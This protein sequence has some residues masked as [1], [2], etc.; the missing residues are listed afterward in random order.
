MFPL[1]HNGA[2][3]GFFRSR[4][5]DGSAN[6]EG[7][8]ATAKE[9]AGAMIYLH[10]VDILHGDLTGSNVLLS[11]SNGDARGFSAKVR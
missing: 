6:M 3:R 7:I 1:S 2:C 11:C 4:R 8:L 10:S 9:I 5:G